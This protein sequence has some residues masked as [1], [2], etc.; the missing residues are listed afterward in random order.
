MAVA[1]TTKTAW[2]LRECRRAAEE[3]PQ[4]VKGVEEAV[5]SRNQLIPALGVGAPALF[6]KLLT[7]IFN[8]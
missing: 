8:S 1:V 5:C 6:P 4:R 2:K 7:G 3:V